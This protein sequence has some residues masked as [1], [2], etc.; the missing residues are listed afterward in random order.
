MHKMPSSARTVLSQTHKTL[1]GSLDLAMV[2]RGRGRGAE[3]AA[4]S[5]ALKLESKAALHLP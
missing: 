3:V 2:G 4:A 1:L 5:H